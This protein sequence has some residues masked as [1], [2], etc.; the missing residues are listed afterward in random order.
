MR[1]TIGSLALVALF[2]SALFVRGAVA[3]EQPPQE[4]APAQ[5]QAQ[6]QEAQ[7]QDAQQQD[8]QQ[9]RARQQ[10]RQQ[11]AGQQRAGQQGAGLDEHIAACLLLA[12]QEE[13]ALA[14][15]AK[16]KCESE[17]CK[18]FAQKLID[19]HQQALAKIEQAAPR[20]ATEE[21]VLRNTSLNRN[22]RAED[23]GRAQRDAQSDAR[24]E[25][26]ADAAAAEQAETQAETPANE[27]PVARTERQ[28]AQGQDR[29]AARAGGQ[30]AALEPSLMLA[31]Q[32]KE[33]C[34]AASVTAL[35]EK[36]GAEF[37][38]C[39]IDQQVMAHKL[40]TAQLKG[41]EPFASAQLKPLI[42]QSLK[43]TESHLAKA[44]ELQKKL[45]KD[46]DSE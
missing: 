33:E 32:I 15:F 35:E 26:R 17:E 24:S 44:E 1:K 36:E 16:E 5:Q 6:Q 3:Q 27:R 21:L 34:L 28:P 29:T 42:Q 37:D 22:A 10:A 31:R 46:K 11:R 9:Q 23:Q 14:K 7:P 4:G 43:T 20:L 18:E 39:F 45:K 13:V 2:G 12:N 8:A 40:M 25:D 19:D 38:R 41:S 30:S